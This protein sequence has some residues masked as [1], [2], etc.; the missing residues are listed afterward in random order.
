MQN[1]SQKA[2]VLS[3]FS[4][5]DRTIP[6]LANWAVTKQHLEEDVIVGISDNVERPT[7]GLSAAAEKKNHCALP[8]TVER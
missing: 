1:G 8:L 5:S 3:V 2:H 6:N 7:R 4:G